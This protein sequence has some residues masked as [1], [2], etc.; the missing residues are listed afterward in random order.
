MKYPV[1]IEIVVSA[2]RWWSNWFKDKAVPAL[3]GPEVMKHTCP[4]GAR[5]FRIYGPGGDSVVASA[6]QSFLQLEK[7]GELEPGSW[8][9]LT[10]CFRDEEEVEEIRL[11]VFLKLELIR[12]SDEMNYYTATEALWLAKKLQ[13]FFKEFYGLPTEIQKTGDGW[14]VMYQDL[15]LGSFGVRHTLNDKSYIYGTGLAEPRASI[16]L[17]RFHESN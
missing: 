12:L 5:D 9:A 10:P 14:D 15:E 11:P 1:D 4:E 7:D 16:A 2:H 6:E 13:K 8:M 17:R 3:V